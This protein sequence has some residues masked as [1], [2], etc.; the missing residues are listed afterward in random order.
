LAISGGSLD[1]L[2]L[3]LL[4]LIAAAVLVVVNAVEIG[5][6]LKRWWYG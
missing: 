6:Q 3:L 5:Q 4:V 1:L 2:T